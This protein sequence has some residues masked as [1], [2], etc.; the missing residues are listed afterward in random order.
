MAELKSESRSG[1]RVE[2][3]SGFE[4]RWSRV[5]RGTS[6]VDAEVDIALGD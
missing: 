4:N 3:L 6:G 2:S 5:G 1:L